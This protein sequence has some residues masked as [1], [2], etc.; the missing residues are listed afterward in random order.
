MGEEEV[1]AVEAEVEG[2]EVVVEGVEVVVEGVEVVVEVNNFSCHPSKY[3]SQHA[4]GLKAPRD[5]IFPIS[6]LQ[7]CWHTRTGF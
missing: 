3:F 6:Y 4:I 2:V 7:K 1:E 5:L